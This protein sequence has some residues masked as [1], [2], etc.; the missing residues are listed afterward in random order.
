MLTDQ[1]AT[2]RGNIE[3]L[4]QH[5]SDPDDFSSESDGKRE[6]EVSGT[7]IHLD[8]GCCPG[9][10]GQPHVNCALAL[11]HLA[12]V[13]NDV[14]YQQD[15]LER[16]V[17]TLSCLMDTINGQI[18]PLVAQTTS[19]TTHVNGVASTLAVQQIKIDKFGAATNTA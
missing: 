14:A 6:T 18:T 16:K 17:Q 1:V 9:L 10:E 13:T 12:A 2:L 11:D 15:A 8:H 7:P 5:L 4:R 19:L 3:Y